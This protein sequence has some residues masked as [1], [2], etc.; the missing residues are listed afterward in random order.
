MCA[1]TYELVSCIQAQFD[2]LQVIFLLQW[3]S[4]F[5]RTRVCPKSFFLNF[6]RG[7]RQ[8]SY[9]YVAFVHWSH[10]SVCPCGFHFS[11]Q[12]STR[13]MRWYVWAGQLHTGS[14]WCPQGKDAILME[15]ST[16]PEWSLNSLTHH[17]P[18]TH[19]L[20]CK[21]DDS[22]RICAYR[23][24]PKFYVFASVFRGLGEKTVITSPP[25]KF[26][27]WS[28]WTPCGLWR[29]LSKCCTQSM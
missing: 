5:T 15:A 2:W 6:W 1:G 8:R 25:Y 7:D 27:D 4:T 21:L 3:Q 18:L 14:D 23:Q 9:T 20:P 29:H 17:R 10:G 13:C 22:D 28:L 16:F 11:S 19:G 26:H 24:G 12:S